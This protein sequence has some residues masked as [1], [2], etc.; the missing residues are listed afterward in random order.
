MEKQKFN[1]ILFSIFLGLLLVLLV[2]FFII[3][4]GV[5][6]QLKG[7]DFVEIGIH[8]DYEDAGYEVTFF[9]KKVDAFVKVK[10]NLDVHTLGTYQIKYTLSY[11]GLKFDAIRM[12]QVVDYESPTITLYGEETVF[13]FA[14]DDYIENGAIAFD[15]LEGD[16]TNKIKIDSNLNSEK[17]GEYKVFYRVQD[18][19][20]NATSVERTIIVSQKVS[21]KNNPMVQYVTEH[22][23]P[24][25]FGYYNLVTGDSYFY[26][27]DKVYYAASLIKVVEAL[28][29]YDHD[30]VNENTK[31][32]IKKIIT[33]SDNPSHHYLQELIGKNNLRAYG[34]SLGAKYVLPTNDA[35]GTTTV[36]DQIVFLKRLYE[37]TKDNKNEELK[38]WFINDYGNHLHLDNGISIM[39]KYGLYD[40]VYHDVGIVLDEQPYII[41]VLTEI[42]EGFPPIV[43]GLAKIMYQYHLSRK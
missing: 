3:R 16:I 11:I 9:G 31:E 38:S 35:C 39:H 10:S 37:I 34:K 2:F 6:F 43:N 13:L 14:G 17:V 40:Q 8:S 19:F 33:R 18:E 42:P 26:N 21:E 41:V 15:N 4:K 5:Q 1:F 27:E 32:Y 25:S 30:M 22:N 24:I 23:Y 28:Y 12:I 7:N 36:T 29:L 20:G